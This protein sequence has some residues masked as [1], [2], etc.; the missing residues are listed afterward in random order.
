MFAPH[1][2]EIASQSKQRTGRNT[3]LL[4]TDGKLDKMPKTA[5]KCCGHNLKAPMRG[6]AVGV[7]TVAEGGL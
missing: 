1:A 4:P 3:K 2:M 7:A 6:V 5:E